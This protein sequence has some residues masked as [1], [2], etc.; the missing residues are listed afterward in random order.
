[1]PCQAADVRII[2]MHDISP[3]D[4]LEDLASYHDLAA[5]VEGLRATY[6]RPLASHPDQRVRDQLASLEACLSASL[7]ALDS[8]RA[9]EQ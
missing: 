9:V 2:P 1:M 5:E 7:L 6:L 3:T 4:A 8:L